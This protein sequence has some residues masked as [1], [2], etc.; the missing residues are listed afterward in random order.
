MLLTGVLLELY[1]VAA[2]ITITL[3]DTPV[4]Q[5]TLFLMD[6]AQLLVS[7]PVEAG[8]AAFLTATVIEPRLARL[9]RT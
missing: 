4:E 6:P 9:G 1:G 3:A 7:T 5:D 2:V 8:M